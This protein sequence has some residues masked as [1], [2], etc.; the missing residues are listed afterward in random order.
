MSLVL[1]G[2]DRAVAGGPARRS[3]T[4]G[5]SSVLPYV[6]EAAMAAAVA[7]RAGRPDVELDDVRN[8]LRA[9]LG[10]PEQS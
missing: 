10:A 6:Q 8:R 7:R 3:A 5:C 4:T 1:V 2:E 9:L